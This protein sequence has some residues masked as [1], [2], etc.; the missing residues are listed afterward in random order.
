[1]MVSKALDYALR[2]L[3]YMAQNSE[4]QFFG[5]KE[6]AE[7]LDVSRSYL[8]KVLQGLV[9]ADYL[10]SQTG[11]GGGFGLTPEVTQASL[12]EILRHLDGNDLES[13]CVLGLGVCE[14]DNPCP[15][16]HVWKKGRKEI[17]A[18]LANTTVGDTVDR[19]W[20]HYK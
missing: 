9:Q 20:P 17:L 12:L 15:V 6:I 10:I 14:E 19:Y 8:G 18:Q 1:M 5:V 3:K 2:S 16:H 4:R 13:Q 11:P 7:K